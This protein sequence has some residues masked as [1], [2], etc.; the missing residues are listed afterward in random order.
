[1][2]ADGVWGA[3]SRTWRFRYDGPGRV[4]ETRYEVSDRT[5][6]IAWEPPERGT[7]IVRYEV[8]GS[9]EQGFIP[10]AEDFVF[11]DGASNG[12]YPANLLAVV[13][14]RKLV[15]VDGQDEGGCPNRVYYRIVAVDE[16]GNRGCPSECLGLPHP[17]IYSVPVTEA[18][19]GLVYQYA[20]KA[21]QARPATAYYDTVKRTIDHRA[22]RLHYCLLDAPP[23]LRIDERSGLV[24]GVPPAGTQGEH[25]VSF[26]VCGRRVR[27]EE[28][29]GR[30]QQTFVLHVQGM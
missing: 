24:S 3:W 29:T 5:I 18:V 27:D 10:T 8:Y 20:V 17:F 14:G 2:N 12:V 1:M 28:E 30:D 25:Q 22:E 15:V 4:T 19:E 21:L 13:E 7:P 16:K 11:Y 6:A 26:E 9:D 23:W